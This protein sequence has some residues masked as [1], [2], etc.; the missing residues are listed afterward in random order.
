MTRFS[1]SAGTDGCARLPARWFP[2]FLAS[3]LFGLAAPADAESVPMTAE[4][5]TIEGE[6]A[7]V[8]QAG[9]PALRL[10]DGSEGRLR[11]G[12]AVLDNSHFG[13]G[14]IEFDLLAQPGRDFVGFA[15]RAQESGDAELF[16]IRTH[17]NGNPDSTQY[18]PIVNGSWAWQI[19][20]G[21]GFMSQTR[22]NLGQPM[23]VRADIYEASMLI[24]VDGA[25][26]L[27][28]PHLKSRSRSGTIQLTAAAGAIFSNFS[29]TE[30]AGY[31]DPTP[32]P[33]LPPLAPGTVAAWQVSPA[34]AEEEAMRR[35][36]D[37]Q[38]AGVDWQR[39]PV[40][41]NGIA[42]LSLA[43]P[44]A[45]PRHSYIARFALRSATAR[46]AAM[47]FGFSDKV[48]IFLNGRPIYA[49]DDTQASRDYRFLGL[50]GLWDTLFLPLE[51]GRNE[52]AFVVTDGTNGGTAA[53][54][55]FEDAGIAIEAT[56]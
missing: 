6:G 53:T 39:I 26:I 15:F 2:L 12:A 42:N 3:L 31:R 51:A 4:R 47:Q 23:H 33:P 25:P 48:R 19:F 32:A 56:D 40:E 27:V 45:D 54:A 5:W 22:F 11:G 14:T 28:V 49:G 44:D 35:A 30:I 10:G 38:W 13:T 18:T 52:I 8:E 34:I 1:P 41:S 55:R 17:M 37:R 21:E 50:V 24:S 7:F 46:T 16:Y 29:V 9:R 20:T 36:A 43:G